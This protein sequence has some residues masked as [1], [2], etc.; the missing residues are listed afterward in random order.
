MA[1]ARNLQKNTPRSRFPKK[2]RSSKGGKY[3]V[4]ALIVFAVA[5]GIYGIMNLERLKP[6]EE[7]KVELK[8]ETGDRPLSQEIRIIIDASGGLRLRAEPSTK[9]EIL[10]TI[11]D[12]TE[13]V[14]QE[15]LN[16]W[17][18][19][20]YKGKTGWIH[21]DYTQRISDD[22]ESSQ[23]EA[24]KW[25]DY[26]SKEFGYSIKMPPDWVVKDYGAN[27]AANLVNYTGFGLQLSDTLNPSLLPPVAVKVT[28]DSFDEVTKNYREK[29]DSV[30][31]KTTIAGLEA[32]KYTF[33]SSSGVL[34]NAYV[35]SKN[36]YTFIIEESG[37]YSEELDKMAS[38]FKV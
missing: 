4:I 23:E 22:N 25:K 13:L 2:S 29:I 16:E 32:R 21:R 6:A 10:A 35:V 5:A 27:E 37:G 1:L 38:A 19:V 7:D 3:L 30:E 26:Q 12:K 9:S 18:K 14:A 36:N 15:V 17:Y 20:E 8:L 31:S 11:P 24:E 33:N 28:E 34:M